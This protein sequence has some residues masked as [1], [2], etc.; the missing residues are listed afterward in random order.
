MFRKIKQVLK[1]KDAKVL[2]ENFL[3][4]SLL[5]VVGYILPFVTLPYL[6]KTIGANKFGEIAF[7]GAVIV[8]FQTFVDY[9]FNY[10]GIRDISRIKDNKKEVSLVLSKIILAR[11]LLMTVGG[12][13]LL[14]C[15]F[16][17]PDFKSNIKILFFTFL[18][19][20]GYIMYPEWFFQALEKMKFSAV[21]STI[22][23]IIFTISIFSLVKK[24]ED[25]LYIPLI[26]AVG[27]LIVGVFSLI[28]IYRMGYRFYFVS[29]K[30]VMKVIVES[31][32]M[33]ISLILPNLYTNMS[34]IFLSSTWGK[35]VTG[36]F[37][38]GYKF[39]GVSQQITNVLSRTFYPFLARRID[40][41]GFY[42]KVSFTVSSIIT[43]ILF[44]GAPLIV[45][46]LLTPEFNEAVTVIRI[47][48]IAPIF[49]FM[50]NAYGTNYLVLKGKEHVL[51]N[52][53][54][55]CS[56]FGLLFS[57]Y[58]VSKYSFKGA[59]IAITVVWGIRG[60]LTWY[61]A[62]YYKRINNNNY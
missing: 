35:G 21:F 56:V 4:L 49:L 62:R 7:A 40:K 58:M 42:E 32:N 25:Y 27:F 55:V 52:I 23:K 45:D 13:I 53:V 38:A 6:A 2:L 24:E 10:T 18:L 26:N 36:I 14:A 47:M 46:I 29:I 15:I 9:G 3:S 11:T 30:E 44:F 1:T 8:F 28:T 22:I 34:I 57:W 54:I 16:I 61:Y 31:T 5:R 37:D 60:C 12:L 17:F 50:M 33:F 19:I 59:A 41:H 48:S 20:P 43:L 51:R 39:V